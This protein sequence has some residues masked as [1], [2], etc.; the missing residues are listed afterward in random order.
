MVRRT[1]RVELGVDALPSASI[2]PTA[3]GVGLGD[4]RRF[5][6]ALDAHVV[7]ELDFGFLGGAGDRRRAAGSGEQAS[8]MWP[9]PANRP[10]V[11]SRPTQPAPGR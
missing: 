6:D 2:S 11:A 5:P 9:S 1:S 10:E 3:L 4:A 7:R 8:G